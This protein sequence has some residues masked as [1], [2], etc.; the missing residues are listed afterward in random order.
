M[1]SLFAAIA[2]LFAAEPVL[3]HPAPFSFV[4]IQIATGGIHGALVIHD[5]DAA[6]EL[7]LDK[8]QALLHLDV[9][10]RYRIQLIH[11]VDLRLR[12]TGDRP[13]TPKWE[14]IETLPERQSL[15]IP[16]T[17][18]KETSGALRIDADLFPY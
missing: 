10:H 7:R 6:N 14:E 15:R 17:I 2:L 18:D 8:P 16:F 5:F 12:F 13:L 9:A 1:R 3:A 4:D 11:L